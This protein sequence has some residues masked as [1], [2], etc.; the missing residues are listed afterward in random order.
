MSKICQKFQ[1]STLIVP[2]FLK[3]DGFCQKLTVIFEIFDICRK[4]LNI[5]N[6][7]R[8]IC[9]W[10]GQIGSFLK[11]KMSKIIPEFLRFLTV[12][13]LSTF[14]RLSKMYQN[15][16][17]FTFAKGSIILQKC[18]E[19]WKPYRNAWPYF[20]QLE[21]TVEILGCKKPFVTF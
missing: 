12:N 19:V 4:F 20:W 18:M 17:H 9:D 5:F 7:F 16:W 3:I 15:I 13:R 14:D 1:K 21:S 8:G 11:S 10:F 2:E 6:I